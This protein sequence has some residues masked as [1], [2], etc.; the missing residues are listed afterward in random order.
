M[1]HASSGERRILGVETWERGRW[2]S[3]PD[4]GG[5]I[6]RGRLPIYQFVAGCVDFRPKSLL[7]FDPR[8]GCLVRCLRDEPLQS[9]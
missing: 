9:D 2:P 1:C 7:K 8:I 6:D 5:P 3:V 4:S